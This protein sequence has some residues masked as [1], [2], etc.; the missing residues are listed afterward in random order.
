MNIDFEINH[1]QQRVAILQINDLQ[2]LFARIL[3]TEPEYI[4]IEFY[5]EC[6]RVV[7]DDTK[8]PKVIN[9]H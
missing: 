1:V 7:A 5:P 9:A 4:K 3:V 8:L 6:I 2:K